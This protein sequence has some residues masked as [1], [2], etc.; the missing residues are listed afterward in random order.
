MK[1]LAI[2]GLVA[3]ISLGA[4]PA[5]RPTSKS[6]PASATKPAPTPYADLLRKAGFEKWLKDGNR[7]P[8]EVALVITRFNKDRPSFTCTTQVDSVDV[9]GG[10]TKFSYEETARL[11]YVALITRFEY[12][13]K[14]FI[15]A[16]SAQI[17]VTLK[18]CYDAMVLD[19]PALGPNRVYNRLEVKSVKVLK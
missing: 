17:E 3:S 6:Q 10:T 5:S 15:S 1:M 14:G 4:G 18:N 11:G 7:S 12:Q 16:K 13:Q 19:Q 8:A 9:D 2:L